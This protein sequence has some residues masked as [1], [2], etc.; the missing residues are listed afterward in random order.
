MGGYIPGQKPGRMPDDTDRDGGQD[1]DES[2]H[3][4]LRDIYHIP[5]AYLTTL[6]A[7][8]ASLQG[9]FAEIDRRAALNQLR[10]LHIFQSRGVTDFHLNGSTGYGYGDSGREVLEQ[11]FASYFGGE[12]ALVRSQI[13][14]GTHAIALGLYGNLK[15]GDELVCAAG[16]PYDTLQKVIGLHEE[17]DSLIE[18]GVSYR[19]IPLASDVDDRDVVDLPRLIDAIDSRTKM[20][21][22]QRSK[23][24]H[25]RPSVGIDEL[26]SILSAIK[27]KRPDVVCL[28]DNCYC[29]MTE[30]REP[31]ELGADLVIGSLIKNPGGTL[32]PCGGYIVGKAPYVEACA[33]RLSAPGLSPELGASLGFNRPAF[34]G[35]YQAPQVVSQSMKGAVLAGA[36]FAGLGYAVMPETSV[37]RADIV[38]AIRLGSEDKLLR[39]CRA[40][41]K[42]CPLDATFAPEPAMLP[43]YRHPVIMAGGGFIQGSSGEL[44]ADGPLRP[45]YDVFMQGGFSLAQIRL[46]LLLAATDLDAS[47]PIQDESP[48]ERE[49]AR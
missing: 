22:I 32:A 15:P 14:S 20:V 4:F 27:A 34:Q 41:Q 28:V 33:R 6:D 36:F 26:G 29:E 37:D 17:A 25:W 8:E 10:L 13:Q 3:R 43:G 7:A 2:L 38:Q 40:I 31:G 9:A 44:S 45:P 11:V 39:F 46:G 12:A 24:Y 23:G 42:A 47:A 5:Q 1:T 48:P 16:P 35:L 21:F 19:E 30:T 49:A 18:S